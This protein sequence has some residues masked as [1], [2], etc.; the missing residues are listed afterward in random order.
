MAGRFCTRCG[1]GCGATARFCAACG[2]SLPAAAGVPPAPP[3]ADWGEVKAATIL[4]ADIADS[5]RQIAELSPEQA[6]QQLQPAIERMVRIVEQHRGTVLRTLGDGIMA[7]FGVPLALEQQA[8][9]ACLAAA[10]MQQSF[11]AAPGGAG[12]ALRIGLHTGKVASDPTEAG[13][14][15]GGG[16]HGVA[17][18]LAS[19]VAAHAEPGQVLLTEETRHLLR[20][21]LLAAR[22]VGSW[23]LKGILQPVPLYAL[24]L[25]VGS[26]SVPDPAERAGRFVGR[27]DELAQLVHA[28]GRTRAGQGQVVCVSGAA[29]SGKTRLCAEFARRCQ[30]Q[31]AQLVWVQAHPLSHA[32]PLRPARELL[33]ALCLGVTP[34]LA[35]AEARRRIA[36]ALA[37]VGHPGAADAALLYEL[38]DVSDA[39]AAPPERP[40][41]G[42][43][44]RQLRLLALVA[45]LVR[46]D[47]DTLRLVVVEDLHW[48]DLASWPIL[49]AVAEALAST[50]TLLLA[51]HRRELA[52]PWPRLGH[53]AVLPLGALAPQALRAIVAERLAAPP[54]PG[55]PAP[56]P[57]GDP[58]AWVDRVVERSQGN[59]FFAQELVRHL[60]RTGAEPARWAAELPDSIDALIAARI[61]ALP[62]TDKRVLQTAAVIGKQVN[63]AVL[64]R[65]LRLPP[66]RLAPALRRLQAAEL[67]MPAEGSHG[68]PALS[69]VHPLIQEV[70]YGAQLRTRLTGVHARVA[71]VLEQRYAHGPR[72]D[73][74]AALMAHHREQAGQPLPAAR[75]AARA[76][77][78]LRSGDAGVVIAAWRKVMLLLEQA[79]EGEEAQALSALAAGRILFLGWRVG[80]TEQEVTQLIERALG[81]A[82]DTDPRLPQLL[83]FA[84]ARMLQ[85]SGGSAD[86]Y[87][88]AIQAVL[89]MPDPPGDPGRRATLHVVLSQAYSWA[90]LLREALAASDVALAGMAQVSAFDH[91]FIGF[92]VEQWAVGLRMRVLCRMGRLAEAKACRDRLARLSRDEPDVVM[93]GI[94]FSLTLELDCLQGRT[95][96]AWAMVRPLDRVARQQNDYLRITDAYFLSLLELSSHHYAV[97]CS[98]IQDGLAYLRERQVAVDFEVELLALSSEAL[99]A[100][101]AWDAAVR[102]AHATLG[103]ARQRGNR[104]AECRAALVLARAD[105]RQGMASERAGAAPQRDWL[106]TAGELLDLTGAELWRPLWRALRARARATALPA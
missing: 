66:S 91:D 88:R 43:D 30:A 13:D 34:A 82:R 8:E 60:R 102:E 98:Q 26:V 65:V 46:A 92:S 85:A 55:V 100:R 103:L 7:L 16:A 14:R 96:Q 24:R 38:M 3:P 67:L 39:D 52:P 12:L 106:A 81:Q 44:S 6:M 58:A 50:H 64:A 29:G 61:D 87:L 51:N 84:H 99:A 80:I 62:E 77:Q 25:D 68:T 71:D 105:E 89:A 40:L 36:A 72:A 15:R 9:Q 54:S 31:G 57:A 76:A 45:D 90:G 21:G 4:F 69:F 97:A 28:L 33:G 10:R 104:V 41:A 1:A 49:N 18:H 63:A 56:S 22:P 27:D 59:P 5:T 42:R 35:P 37:R 83:R 78:W 17:I 74:L 94:A 70:A 53:A 47:A 73:E 19:R 75:H 48:L 101:G 79:P 32:L 11:D 23:H 95:R 20:P 86:D 93:K 2:Q